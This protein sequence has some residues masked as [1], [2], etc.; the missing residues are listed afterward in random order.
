MILTATAS[1]NRGLCAQCVKVPES[2]RRARREFDQA[3]AAGLV[4]IPTEEERRSSKRPSEFDASAHVWKPEP[5][6][7][8]DSQYQSV[9]AVLFAAAS[10]PSGHVFLVS[11]SGARLSLS[12]NRRYGVC[13]YQNEDSG[14]YLYAL[15]AQNSRVQV[16]EEEHLAQACPCCG[17]AVLWYPSRFHMPREQAF[18]V[19]SALPAEPT[20]DSPIVEWLSYGDISHTSPGRG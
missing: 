20:G 14:D 15:S 19:F 3:V 7:Y 11:E 13:E 2:L 1:A 17:E 8:Q 4:F 10:Q 12:F 6:F 16:D 5:E 18:A 9:A